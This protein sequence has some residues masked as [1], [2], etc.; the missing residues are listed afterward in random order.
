MPSHNRLSALRL[1]PVR[2]EPLND[3]QELV[4]A[5]SISLPIYYRPTSECFAGVDGLI[6]MSDAV[7]LIQVTVSSTHALKKER[8]VLLYEN[9]PVSIR[10]R[11]WKF[12]WVVPECDVGE[13]LAKRR[14]DVGGDWPTIQFYWCRFPFDTT[15]SSRIQ[16]SAAGAD[17]CHQEGASKDLKL[18]ITR[19]VIEVDEQIIET[20]EGGDSGEDKDEVMTTLTVKGKG[21]RKKSTPEINLPSTSTATIQGG[22]KKG[23]YMFRAPKKPT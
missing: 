3:I 7:V 11:P 13:V 22:V 20:C 9:L 15:V 21:K 12:V 8:L 23:R 18:D 16:L 4:N 10:K 6:L 2:E 1:Q 19:P 14:F 5:T 17:V